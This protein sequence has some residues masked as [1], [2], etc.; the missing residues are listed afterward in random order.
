MPHRLLLGYT[1]C[2]GS[3]AGNGGVA[4]W[5]WGAAVQSSKGPVSPQ[6]EMVRQWMDRC[7]W[8]G[9]RVQARNVTGV[10]TRRKREGRG[11]RGQWVTT[12]P[13]QEMVVFWKQFRA[14]RTG[15]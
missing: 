7:I 4:S 3:A 14:G 9:R 8:P 1:R 12:Y 15:P 5:A 6:C 2:L 10:I 11:G 13:T